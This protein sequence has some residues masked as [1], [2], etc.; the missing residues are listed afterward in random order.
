MIGHC[1][2]ALVVNELA[3]DIH[4]RT[5]PVSDT[6]LTCLSSILDIESHDVA[7]LLRHPGAVQFTNM[8]IFMMGHLYNSSWT[9]S[10]GS[11]DVLQQTFSI[12]SRT[13]PAPYISQ[14]WPD[15]TDTPVGHS[16]GTSS[17]PHERRRRVFGMYLKSLW[18]FVRAYI[19]LGNSTPL[20]SYFYIAFTHPVINRRILVGDDTSVDVL[21]RCVGAL[22]V[23]KL[24]TDINARTLPV[25]DEE[26]ACLSSILGTDRRD[27]THL[28]FHPG[29]IQFMNMVFL[30]KKDNFAFPFRGTISGMT[31]VVQQTF[32]I[33]SRALPTQLNEEMRLDLPI[34]TSIYF[35]TETSIPYAYAMQRRA[36]CVSL[37]GLWHLTRAYIERGNSTPLPSYIYIAFT[38]SEITRHIRKKGDV[39]ARVIRRCVGALIVNKLVTDISAC[40]LPVNDDN[41]VG[42]SSI[43]DSELHDVRLCLTQPGVLGLVN[44]APFVL[45]GPVGYLKGDDV[46]LNSD[47]ILQ[48]TLGIISHALPVRVNAQ[49]RQD[50]MVALSNLSDDEFERTIVS[51]LH[52]F[53]KTCIPG[54]SESHPTGAIRTSFLRMCLKTLWHSGKAY[55]QGSDSLPSYFP[56]M[57]ASPEITHHLQTE[58]DPVSRLTG[59][60]FGALI[61]SKLVDAFT[62]PVLLGGRVENAELACVSAILGTGHGEGSL[63]PRQLRVINFQ[64]VVS[65]MSNEIDNLFTA[66]GTPA[67]ILAIAQE[68]LHGLANRLRYRGFGLKHAPT[69]HQALLP[70][71]YREVQKAVRPNSGR[72]KGRML[73]T[74]ERLRQLSEKLLLTMGLPQDME[75]QDLDR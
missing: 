46:P 35:F 59:C 12:L 9:P 66:E 22:V 31:D 17:D 32:S 68:T 26:M 48:E 74:L 19:V 3:T 40:A 33:L 23:S 5:V 38:H 70:D 41:L 29:A 61:A 21:R 60:C 56:L 11:L 20:P 50:Q 62:S 36:L 63:S 43:L 25:N 39:A 13:L 6:E 44:L 4:S 55:H 27:A 58:Q 49:L 65:L 1:V 15:L 67:G 52:G 57:L 47:D 45:G 14:I 34:D 71:I 73:K 28:L 72:H 75:M 51:R 8:I 24:A 30:A 18:H 2:G 16:D 7:Y 69:D 64:K 42:L 10:T 54:A 37:E 53:L